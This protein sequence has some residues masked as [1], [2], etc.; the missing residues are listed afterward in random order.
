MGVDKKKS[1]ATPAPESLLFLAKGPEKGQPSEMENIIDNSC[2]TPKKYYGEK[3]VVPH[4]HTYANKG[5]ILE[6]SFYMTFLKW[7]NYRIG[8]GRE[9]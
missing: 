3:L 1:H 6:D 2:S 5:H 9:L 7:D 4:T 8:G